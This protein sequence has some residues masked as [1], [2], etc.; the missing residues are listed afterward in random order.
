[1]LESCYERRA[2]WTTGVR[3]MIRSEDYRGAGIGVR[4]DMPAG[5]LVRS[6]LETRV[7]RELE[8]M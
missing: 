2:A 3:K 8:K 7:T 1:V 6:L 4:I 5:G